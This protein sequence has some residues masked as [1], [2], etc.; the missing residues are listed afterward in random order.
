M[1][2]CAPAQPRMGQPSE[3]G[4]RRAQCR[5]LRST[6]R[7]AQQTH[8]RP[9]AHSLQVGREDGRDAALEVGACHGRRGRVL[10]LLDALGRGPAVLRALPLAQQ[11]LIALAHTGGR[12]A[13]VRP[14]AALALLRPPS[15]RRSTALQLICS[16]AP[17]QAQVV[18]A[19]SASRVRLC[20]SFAAQPQCRRTWCWR[21]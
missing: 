7:L 6:A 15:S 2:T 11:P 19:Q 3:P 10:L 13:V 21:N 17:M 4:R 18:L 16:T 14:L 8:C 5:A 1:T 9:R 12:R 20:S